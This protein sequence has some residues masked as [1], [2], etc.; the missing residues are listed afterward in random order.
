A[1]IERVSRWAFVMSVVISVVAYLLW[2]VIS[3]DPSALNAQLHPIQALG[4]IADQVGQA[5][6]VTDWNIPWWS[7]LVWLV[8]W[9][10]IQGTGAVAVRKLIGKPFS[11]AATG[12]LVNFGVGFVIYAMVQLTIGLVGL[13]RFP[14][15]LPFFLFGCGAL[16]IAGMRENVFR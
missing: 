3:D 2:T 7:L 13:A 12:W 16:F 14:L 10:G 9:I 6:P 8:W 15:I 1:M 5:A 4:A 11:N